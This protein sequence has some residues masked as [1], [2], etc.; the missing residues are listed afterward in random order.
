MMT[1]KNVFLICS[2]CFFHGSGVRRRGGGA[3][4]CPRKD[5]LLRDYSQSPDKRKINIDEL[6]RDRDL[7]PAALYRVKTGG[8]SGL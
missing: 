7:N 3:A 5:R 6:I 8:L 2:L 1:K 4:S